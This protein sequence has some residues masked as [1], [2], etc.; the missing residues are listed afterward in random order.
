MLSHLVVARPGSGQTRINIIFTWLVGFLPV[1]DLQCM[2]ATFQVR[3]KCWAL[4]EGRFLCPPPLPVQGLCG[5]NW[6]L[7]MSSL[8]FMAATV[9]A[10][11]HQTC[12]KV[13][14]TYIVD[15]QIMPAELIEYFENALKELVESW[16]S[17]HSWLVWGYT[18]QS[19]SYNP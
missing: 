18:G 19:G 13:I 8:K 5:E 10:F 4:Y 14:S 17:Q 16:G 3:K 2:C 12:Q 9:M 6:H 11:D 7:R 15:V 1:R